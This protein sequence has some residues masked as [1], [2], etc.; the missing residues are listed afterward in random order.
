MIT[1]SIKNL[2]AEYQD[3][4]KEREQHIMIIAFF[5]LN[6]S[7]LSV[8]KASLL[9]NSLLSAEE[10]VELLNQQRIHIYQQYIRSVNFADNELT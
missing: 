9:F 4:L 6:S 3:E 10:E 8:T 5:R 7:K 2:D 1:E